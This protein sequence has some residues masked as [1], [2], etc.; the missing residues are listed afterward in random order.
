MSTITLQQ[1]YSPGLDPEEV[2][3]LV[4]PL[5]TW[6]TN[7]TPHGSDLASWDDTAQSEVST[8]CVPHL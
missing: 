3:Y 1:G 7:R 6:V 2:P 8:R 5:G 4:R